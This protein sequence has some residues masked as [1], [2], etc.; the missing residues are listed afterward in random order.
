MVV[1]RL[2]NVNDKYIFYKECSTIGGAWKY[3][4]TLTHSTTIKCIGM[5]DEFDTP[6]PPHLIDTYNNQLPNADSIIEYQ[7]YPTYIK[8]EKGD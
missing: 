1:L 6:L 5:R 2:V 8:I 3:L 7:S 4:I